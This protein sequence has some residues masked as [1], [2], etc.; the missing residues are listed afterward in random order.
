MPPERDMSAPR[1]DSG[2]ERSAPSS[3][4]ERD[5]SA[6]RGDSGSERSAPSSAAE[7]DMSASRLPPRGRVCGGRRQGG[8]HKVR[9]M[10]A[11]HPHTVL[12]IGGVKSGK[13]E[14][15]ES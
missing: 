5:M 4:A 13:S 7:R 14:F 1:G 3:A 12:V 2:S 10:S 9:N 6:P 15:A 11:P 8:R